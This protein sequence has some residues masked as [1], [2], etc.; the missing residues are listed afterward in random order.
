MPPDGVRLKA[1]VTASQ[2]ICSDER[3][4]LLEVH[5]M[6]VFE[7]LQR[8]TGDGLDGRGEVPNLVRHRVKRC[9]LRIL[10]S[11]NRGDVALPPLKCS[12]DIKIQVRNYA[13]SSRPLALQRKAHRCSGSH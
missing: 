7:R 4:Y 9:C 13:D 2:L 3:K 12:A 5:A 10:A 6:V 1:H 8:D 11:Q